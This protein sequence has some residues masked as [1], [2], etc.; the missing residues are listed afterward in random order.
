MPASDLMPRKWAM[1]LFKEMEYNTFTKAVIMMLITKT[2]LRIK[3]VEWYLLSKNCNKKSIAHLYA[4]MGVSVGTFKCPCCVFCVQKTGNQVGISTKSKSCRCWLR[5]SIV[6][7]LF[8][9][10]KA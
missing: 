4:I 9:I 6:T 5:F 8:S 3:V 10:E 7:P 1:L 2:K